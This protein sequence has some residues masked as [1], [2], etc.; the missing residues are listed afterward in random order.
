[1]MSLGLSSTSD[2]LT[3]DQN[4]HHLCSTSAGGK[5]LSNDT[6]IKEIGPMEPE[7]LHKNAQKVA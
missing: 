2:V 7:I 3:F 5:D 4:W 6:Q 1:M